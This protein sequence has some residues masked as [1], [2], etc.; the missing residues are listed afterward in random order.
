MVLTQ[1]YRENFN[2][3]SYWIGIISYQADAHKEVV[4]IENEQ[5]GFDDFLVRAPG[6]DCFRKD[7][8]LNLDRR[9]LSRLQVFENGYDSTTTHVLTYEL[10]ENTDGL[11]GS[12]KWFFQLMKSEDVKRICTLK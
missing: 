4:N 3:H 1:Y 2:A 9:P 6:S 7:Y 10:R 8:T 11:P 5:H 12:S